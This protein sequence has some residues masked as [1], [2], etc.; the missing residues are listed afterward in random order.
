[1]CTGEEIVM[2]KKKY[3]VLENAGAHSFCTY[4]KDIIYKVKLIYV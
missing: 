3:S 4:L 2:G 1:M